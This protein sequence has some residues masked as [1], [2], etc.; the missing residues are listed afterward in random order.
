VNAGPATWGQFRSHPVGAALEDLWHTTH[1][2]AERTASGYMLERLADQQVTLEAAAA[3]VAGLASAQDRLSPEGG[4]L[5]SHLTQWR[6]N[7]DLAV[8]AAEVG[9]IL[10][11][12]VAVSRSETAEEDSALAALEVLVSGTPDILADARM[13]SRT[14]DS[15][16]LS[17]VVETIETGVAPLADCVREDFD[18]AG[19]FI[20]AGLPW[21]LDPL[22]ALH[23]CALMLPTAV[24]AEAAGDRRAATVVRRWAY[25]RVRTD[26]AE[27]LSAS[28]LAK[29]RLL[30]AG[31]PIPVVEPGHTT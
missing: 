8:V 12:Q 25:A 31:D 24:A 14:V 4:R 9:V 21:V 11:Q 20:E 5:L 29:T 7:R 6:V 16:Y 15:A 26:T 30:A 18:E 27:G 19:D 13:L 10:G 2:A 22:S 1:D 3:A 17:G 23:T 28:H